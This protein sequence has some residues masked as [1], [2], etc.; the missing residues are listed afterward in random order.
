MHTRQ[1]VRCGNRSKPNRLHNG[2]NHSAGQH[3]IVRSNS[4]P[5]VAK[6]SQNAQSH[7]TTEGNLLFPLHLQAPKHGSWKKSEN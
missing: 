1:V 6:D 2:C 4:S 5:E 3:A 7:E